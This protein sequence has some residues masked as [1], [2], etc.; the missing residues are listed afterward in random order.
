MNSYKKWSADFR[1]RS[2][3]YTQQAQKMGWIPYPKKCNRCGQV[4]G[5]IHTHN[6]DYD[7][8]FYT[9]D[10]V[11]NRFPIS[12]TSEELERLNMVLEPLCWRCHMMHHSKRRAPKAVKQYFQDVASGKQFPPVYKHD[13]NILK[14]DHNVY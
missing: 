10:E 1:R 3:K 5:I 2:L 14:R 9:L 7:V 13:F 8:T 12:I 6:E 11:F 4:H